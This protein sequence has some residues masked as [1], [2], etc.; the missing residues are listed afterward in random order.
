MALLYFKHG[1]K[2]PTRVVESQ[3]MLAKECWV[4]RA[5][6]G[7]SPVWLGPWLT[8]CQ[9]QVAPSCQT[10]P[11]PVLMYIS[12][13]SLAFSSLLSLFFSFYPS[14][15]SVFSSAIVTRHIMGLR[16]PVLLSHLPLAPAFHLH[17]H[18]SA[19]LVLLLSWEPSKSWASCLVFRH[20]FSKHGHCQREFQEQQLSRGT[21]FNESESP[22]IW[23][24]LLENPF[25]HTV[26][27]GRC[28]AH[29]HNVVVWYRE[30][31][32]GGIP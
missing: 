27:S 30:L 29:Q 9:F 26:S 18:A 6:P 2:H 23:W 1:F 5:G 20:C 22:G 8:G 7:W 12:A 13:I 4:V 10:A 21:P 25:H 16:W 14:F 15:Y 32:E 24:S 3:D 19:H 17:L 31:L 28:G 11:P